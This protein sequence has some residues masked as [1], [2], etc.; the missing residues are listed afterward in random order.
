MSDRKRVAELAGRFLP[1]DVAPRWL[2]LLRPGAALRHA[3]PGAPV[4]AVLGGQPRLPD[5][6]DWPVW[7]DHGPLSFVAAIDCAALSAVPL[8]ITLPFGM[9]LFFYFDGRIDN[10]DALVDTGDPAGA[11]VLYV[12][13]DQAISRR[14]CPGS[15]EPYPRVNLAVVPVMTFPT[16]GHPDL[17]AAFKD[18]AEDLQ[19]FLGHPVNGDAFQEALWDRHAGPCHQVGGYASP[20]QWPAEY[21]VADAALRHAGHHVLEHRGDQG[22]GDPRLRA[23]VARWTLL[24]QIDSDHRAGMNWGDAGVLYWLMRRTDRTGSDLEK[25]SFTWQCY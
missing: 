17:Q 13:P 1:A 4:A 3:R 8:D 10:H 12:T 11:R 25:A 19:S 2:R 23:E 7:E 22:D 14:A 5:S 20:V 6:V 16:W 18:P 15:I 9:L 24:A 21:E